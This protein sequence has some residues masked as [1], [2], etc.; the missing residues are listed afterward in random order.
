[1]TLKQSS[2]V[3]I[4]ASYSADVILTGSSSK[5]RHLVINLASVPGG[6]LVNSPTAQSLERCLQCDFTMTDPIKLENFFIDYINTFAYYR[7]SNQKIAAINLWTN[8]YKI[9]HGATVV[10][11]FDIY[12]NV[13]FTETHPPD[14]EILSPFINDALM[15]DTRII[16]CFENFMK[17]LLILNDCVVHKIIRKPLK[18]EQIERPIKIPEVFTEISFAN[19]DKT[20]PELWETSFQTLNFSWMLKPNYQAVINLPKDILTIITAINE[21]RNKLH[22]IKTELFQIGKPTIEKYSKIIE[23]ANTTIRDCILNLDSNLKQMLDKIKTQS[24]AAKPN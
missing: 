24:H 11:G 2:A 5:L 7:E 23:F 16:T 18:Y 10:K 3:H 20:K 8:G 17:G 6:Q 13:E 21:E 14:F 4:Q 1:M 15:D 22:F 19:F 12:K 9:L